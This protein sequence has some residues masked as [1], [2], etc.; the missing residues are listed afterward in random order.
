M[1]V[2]RIFGEHTTVLVP[3]VLEVLF[4]LLLKT[5]GPNETSDDCQTFRVSSKSLIPFAC[6][7]LL[8]GRQT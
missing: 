7:H 1:V 5:I 6:G 8:P 4:V 3:E 2:S